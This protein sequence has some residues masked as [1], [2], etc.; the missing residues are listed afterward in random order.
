MPN[1][2]LCTDIH[3]TF[4]EIEAFK[5]RCY[6]WQCPLTRLQFLIYFYCI[7]VVLRNWVFGV[8][9]TYKPAQYNSIAD[10]RKLWKK[11]SHRRLIKLI[12]FIEF[13]HF[14]LHLQLLHHVLKCCFGVHVIL[15]KCCEISVGAFMRRKASN[16]ICH[17]PRNDLQ[18]F[19]YAIFI[20]VPQK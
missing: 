2:T 1:E 4:H 8:A 5:V 10:I 17:I 20:I 3:T 12:F 16:E 7:R 14:P 18:A 6:Y 15:E 9:S 19:P 13:S 11:Y